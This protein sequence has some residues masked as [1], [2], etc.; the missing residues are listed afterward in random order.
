M[1]DGDVVPA[2]DYK[3]LLDDP[4]GSFEE[5]GVYHDVS[6]EEGDTGTSADPEA[7]EGDA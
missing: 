5:T 6:I 7:T 2:D 3:F 4:E 1:E